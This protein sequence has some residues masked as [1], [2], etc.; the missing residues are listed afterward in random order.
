MIPKLLLGH[1]IF[2][3]ELLSNIK[4]VTNYQA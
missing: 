1:I 2:A 3:K 4:L